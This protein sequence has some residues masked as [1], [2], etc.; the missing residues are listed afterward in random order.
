MT[1]PKV[2]QIWEI[3]SRGRCYLATVT[4]IENEHAT[5]LYQDV[6]EHI[7]ASFTDLRLMK[8]VYRLVRDV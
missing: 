4:H 3:T 7:V 8:D 6:P 5:L 1:E 2:G